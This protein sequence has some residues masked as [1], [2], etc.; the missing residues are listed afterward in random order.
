MATR[1]SRVL[2]SL[3]IPIF[4]A[5]PL[6]LKTALCRRAEGKQAVHACSRVL[7]SA[8]CSMLPDDGALDAA[9][10]DA[11][12]RATLVRPA[13]RGSAAARPRALARRAKGGATARAA[14]GLGP[15]QT[16]PDDRS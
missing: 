12:L 14:R 3:G 7:L 13:T 8:L 4:I 2:I 10:A 15:A 1:Y 9:L 11:R 6:L 16:A 5:T